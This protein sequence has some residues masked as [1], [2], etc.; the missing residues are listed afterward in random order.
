MLLFGFQNPKPHANKNKRLELEIP[1]SKWIDWDSRI[2]SYIKIIQ[3]LVLGFQNPNPK[4]KN[5]TLN[6]DS[7]IQSVKLGFWNPK[8]HE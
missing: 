8:P 3:R 7:R 5:E 4:P 1:E 2:Q 6:W